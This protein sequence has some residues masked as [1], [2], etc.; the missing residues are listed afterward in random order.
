MNEKTKICT[1]CSTVNESDY[2]YC[3]NC[4]AAL[5]LEQEEREEPINTN[6]YYPSDTIEGISVENMTCFVGKNNEKIIPQFARMEMTQKKTSF[7]WPVFILTFLFGLCGAAFWFLYRRMYKLGVVLLLLSLLFTAG[8]TMFTVDAMEGFIRDYFDVLENYTATADDMQLQEDMLELLSSEEMVAVSSISNL[9]NAARMALSI[10]GGLFALHIYKKFAA[11]KIKSFGRPLSDMEL[12]L[13]GGTS[14]GAAAV[15]IV[16]YYMVTIA[17][18]MIMTIS[19][20]A[21]LL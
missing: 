13:A 10:L 18:I 7:C 8:T 4:G 17:A 16:L 6:S 3:K 1:E 20:L 11:R 19:Y 21:V 9:L 5:P 2:K 15:G 14:G 12:Y